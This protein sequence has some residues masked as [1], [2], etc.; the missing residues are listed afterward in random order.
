MRRAEGTRNVKWFD[1]KLAALPPQA[2]FAFGTVVLPQNL[3]R[4][5]WL[6]VSDGW[7]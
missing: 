5:N 7:R 6:V 4:A 3:I 2:N 1:L